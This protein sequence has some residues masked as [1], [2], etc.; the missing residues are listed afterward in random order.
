MS[1]YTYPIIASADI[2]G[3]RQ[4]IAGAGLAGVAPTFALVPGPGSGVAYPAK[5]ANG[6]YTYGDPSDLTSLVLD[7]GGLFDLH[8]SVGLSLRS[9]RAFCGGASTFN[10]YIQD[11]GGSNITTIAT[12][13]DANGTSTRYD[14]DGLIILPGQ[15][16]KVTTTAAGTVDLYFVRYS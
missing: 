6:L 9:V 10:L 5:F 16:V 3:V 1:T 14:S 7:A 11:R 15:N 13:V 8:S 4:T 12:T 2:V